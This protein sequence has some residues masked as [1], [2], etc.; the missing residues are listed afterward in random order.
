MRLLRSV[1]IWISSS[2]ITIGQDHA[3]DRHHD[4]VREVLDHVENVAVPALRGL[5]HLYGYIRDLLVTLSN[6]PL[7]FP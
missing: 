6:I 3:S 5:A 1:I 4:G 7:S 2:V